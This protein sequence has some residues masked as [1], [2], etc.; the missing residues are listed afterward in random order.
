M[1]KPQIMVVTG[2]R[3]DFGHLLSVVDSLD[4]DRRVTVEVVAIGAH[5]V[6]E[7]GTTISDVADRF[8][9]AESLKIDIPSDNPFDIA[10]AYAETLAGMNGILSRRRP[11]LLLVLGDRWEIHASATAAV[12]L[13]IPLAHIHG[14]EETHGSLD[15]VFRHSIS[16]AAKIHFP[17]TATA[18]ERIARIVGGRVNI[19]V[20]GAP[21]LDSLKEVRYIEKAGLSEILGI[22][23]KPPVLAISYHPSTATAGRTANEVKKIVSVLK[24]YAGAQVLIGS[25][26]E[27]EYAQVHY[28]FRKYAAAAKNAIF[29]PHMP[30]DVYLSLLRA[31]DVLVGN[32]SSGLIEA[33]SLKTAVVNVGDRQQ[34]R[35]RAKNVI[36]VTDRDGSFSARAL[37][38][39]I[40]K[41]LSSAFR[42]SLRNVKNPY[43]DGKAGPKIARKLVQILLKNRRY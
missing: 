18:R 35:A 28:G 33:P 27:A 39:G 26:L 10:N 1:R 23:L 30:R 19:H 21:G 38:D 37:K 22:E 36:D 8:R 12:V 24:K 3:A 40:E 15:N 14:G 20:Y 5:L 29:T 2:S 6:H 17:P 13:G 9:V 25:G 42:K 16:L 32:S 43:G 31:S 4:R 34:G 41:A 11:D 7:F